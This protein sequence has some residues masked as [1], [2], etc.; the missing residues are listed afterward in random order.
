MNRIARYSLLAIAVSTLAAAA[1]YYFGQPHTVEPPP[2]EMPS[3][4]PTADAPAR[5]LA[6]TLRDLK[7]KPQPLLQWKGKVLVANFWATWCPPC[8]EEIL[9]FSIIHSKYTANGV[10][11]VGISIDTP[12]KVAVFQEQVRVSYPLL[13]SDLDTLDLASDLGNR[14]KALPFT[15]ILRRDGTLHE[16]KLGKF[17]T[18][19][20]EKA[21]ESALKQ[22]RS[23]S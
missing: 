19:A 4:V 15:V 18:P 14:A 8:K 9:E 21:I 16:V 23:S 12:E 10:Q 3:A 11:F 1:V 13:I 6:L 2:S 5:L 17:A 22:G 20:L 7:G